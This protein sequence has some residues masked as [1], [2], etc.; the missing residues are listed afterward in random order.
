MIMQTGVA[1]SIVSNWVR[2][3]ERVVELDLDTPDNMIGGDGIIMEI[4]ES[5]FG[6]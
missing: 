4:D 5:K 3:F 2:I 6:K 1:S